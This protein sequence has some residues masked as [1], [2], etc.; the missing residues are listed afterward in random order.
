MLGDFEAARALLGRQAEI[1]RDLGIN[2]EDYWLGIAIWKVHML[3]GDPIGAERGIRASFADV[4]QAGRAHGQDESPAT[5]GRLAHSLCAQGRYE[6]AAA[7]A[8][9]EWDINVQGLVSEIIC[10]SASAKAAA[11]VADPDAALELARQAV[12]LAADTDALQV[13]GNAL[14]DLADVLVAIGRAAEAAAP[15][16]DAIQTTGCHDQALVVGDHGGHVIPQRKNAWSAAG[17]DG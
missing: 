2:Y 16:E 7:Y 1:I 17:R 4:V 6:E 10:R 15:I 11:R 9:V 14:M 5:L 8:P 3:A 13:H 12:A